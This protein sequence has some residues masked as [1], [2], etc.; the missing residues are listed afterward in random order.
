MVT[1]RN[2]ERLRAAGPGERSLVIH[3]WTLADGWDDPH[4]LDIAVARVDGAG[5]GRCRVTARRG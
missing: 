3:A 2:W 1:S 4:F 5:A